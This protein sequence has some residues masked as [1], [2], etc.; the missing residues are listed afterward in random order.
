MYQIIELAGALIQKDIVQ[1]ATAFLLK[2]MEK[3]INMHI[4]DDALKKQPL[5]Q[6]QYNKETILTG[7]LTVTL[8]G[9]H[10]A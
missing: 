8:L 1:F 5:R 7:L 3:V 10:I 6:Q 4:V 2:T 9:M